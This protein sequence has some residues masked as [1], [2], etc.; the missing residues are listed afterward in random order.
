[1]YEEL[2]PEPT[3]ELVLLGGVVRR[4]YRSL[5]GFL[6]EDALR[7]LRADRAFLGAAGV[8]DDLSVMDTTMVEVPIKR[9]MIAAAAEVVLLVGARKFG[10]PGVA[11][12]CGPDEIDVLV[13][14]ADAPA[15]ALAPAAERGVRVVRA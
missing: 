10:A 7:Q 12:I 13:T 6:A 8:R 9:G 1:V 15:D 2:L 4:N 11:R 5:V 3:V 14:S